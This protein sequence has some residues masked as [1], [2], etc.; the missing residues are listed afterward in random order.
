M[1]HTSHQKKIIETEEQTHIL[2]TGFVNAYVES[3]NLL[4]RILMQELSYILYSCN[5]S[6]TK[7]LAV[8]LHS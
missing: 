7:D 1:I 3:V 2:V 8:F 6:I 5:V 4:Y